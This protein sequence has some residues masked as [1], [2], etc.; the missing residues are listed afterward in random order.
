MVLPPTH[1]PYITLVQNLSLTTDIEDNGAR[2]PFHSLTP[3]VSR[4]E[5][6]INRLLLGEDLHSKW[7]QH[8]QAHSLGLSLIMFSLVSLD[9]MIGTGLMDVHGEVYAGISLVSQLREHLLP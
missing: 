6:R 3:I 8:L 2:T 5:H 1:P 4:L 7:L 9:D